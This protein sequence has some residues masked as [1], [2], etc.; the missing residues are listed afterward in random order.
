VIE[1]LA[2]DPMASIDV[3]HMC[4]QEGYEVMEIERHGPVARMRLRWPV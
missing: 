4:A 3:P 2:D 1:I